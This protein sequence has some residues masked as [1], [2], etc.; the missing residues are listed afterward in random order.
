MFYD[1]EAIEKI[2]Q[3]YDYGVNLAVNMMTQSKQAVFNAVDE[4][5]KK[6]SILFEQVKQGIETI[7]S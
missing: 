2:K 7:F 3:S 4:N 1:P 5:Y 6:D